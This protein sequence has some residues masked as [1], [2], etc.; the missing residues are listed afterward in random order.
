MIK[1]RESARKRLLS[2]LVR[3]DLEELS[4]MEAPWHADRAT[5]ISHALARWDAESVRRAIE[6]IMK[7]AGPES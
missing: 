6:R 4:G 5:L 2:I 3:N 1:T 7:T